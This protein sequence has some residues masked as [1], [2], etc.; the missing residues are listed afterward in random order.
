MVRK[1]VLV[2]VGGAL[3]S[4]ASVSLVFAGIASPARAFKS[5]RRHMLSGSC[6]APAMNVLSCSSDCI[7]Q[8]SL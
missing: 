3:V 8:L 5:S 6:D 7:A 4:V 1:S 2:A